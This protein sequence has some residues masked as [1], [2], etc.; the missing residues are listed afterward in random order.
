MSQAHYIT[1][2]V[3]ATGKVIVNTPKAKQTRVISST[4]ADNMTRMMLGTYTNGT[5]VGSAPS[6]YTI[7][8]KT[9]TTENSLDQ[10]NANSSKDSWAMAYTKDIVEATWMGLE[11]KN[12][13]SNSLPLGLT[14]TMGPLVK[15]SLEQILPNTSQSTFTVTNPNAT[16]SSSNSSS[17]SDIW[18]TI[19]KDFNT[20]VKKAVDGAG[21]LWDTVTGLFGQ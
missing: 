5:G 4:V 8:G 21:K 18:G 19:Q 11:G 16:T 14:S 15:T 20:G 3:D 1:K 9:G 2:I 6:G 13:Q 17:S 7:A 10:N 12:A